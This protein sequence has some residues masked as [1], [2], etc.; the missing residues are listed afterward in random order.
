MPAT[1]PPQLEHTPGAFVVVTDEIFDAGVFRVNYV[2]SWRIVKS[3][4]AEADYIQVVFVA[5]DES[6]ITI[7]QVENAGEPTGDDE[8][9]ITL[10]NDV[11]VQ[12][13]VDPSDEPDDSFE[14]AA[15]RLIDSI[16]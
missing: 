8:Q 7:L 1:T 14:E 13:I 12:V 16:R 4:I 11:V 10:E 3:S 2:P 5:P 9:F 6:T 15:Q